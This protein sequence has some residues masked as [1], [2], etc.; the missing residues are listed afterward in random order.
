MSHYPYL[1]KDYI[2]SVLDD[3]DIKNSPEWK[4]HLNSEILGKYLEIKQEYKQNNKSTKIV[5]KFGIKIN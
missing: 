1:D 4:Y 3:Y 5:Q 2:H